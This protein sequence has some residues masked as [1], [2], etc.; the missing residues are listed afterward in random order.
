MPPAGTVSC[1]RP[2]HAGFFSFSVCDMIE[3]RFLMKRGAPGWTELAEDLTREDTRAF[4][5]F[6]PRLCPGSLLERRT[7]TG[8]PTFFPPCSGRRWRKSTAAP[9]P[10]EELSSPSGR[11]QV[12]AGSGRSRLCLHAD[13]SERLEGL[14]PAGHGCSRKK[15]FSC[16]FRAALHPRIQ[17]FSSGYHPFC[18]RSSPGH[19]RGQGRG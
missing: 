10:Q 2:P 16:R 17:P 12:S 4:P 15:P 3:K 18:E 5:S 6:P 9:S 1:A 11:S 7:G 13:P 19:D 8:R 14:A